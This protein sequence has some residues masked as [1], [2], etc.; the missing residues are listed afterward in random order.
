MAT[1]N[2]GVAVT[3]LQARI[4]QEIDAQLERSDDTPLS[5][6]GIVDTQTGDTRVLDLTWMRKYALMHNAKGERNEQNLR[7]FFKARMY[8][9]TYTNGVRI[10]LEDIED[11]I[12]MLNPEG[13][14][15]TLLRGYRQ[16]LEEEETAMLTNAFN[17]K[18]VGGSMTGPN[19]ETIYQ[20]SMDGEP[21]LSDSHP[22]FE[23]VEFDENAPRPE[24][25]KVID[26]GTFSNLVNT[27]L[28]EDAL[29]SAWESFQTLVDFQGRPANFG[30][31]DTLVV[32]P[33]QA[34]K[35]RQI[36]GRET[37]LV[38]SSANDAAASVENETE[39]LFNIYVN[40]YLTGSV[41]G[42]D[43]DF[44]G[45]TYTDQTIDLDNVWYLVNTDASVSPFVLWN[46]KPFELQMP[47]GTPDLDAENPAEGEITRDMYEHGAV[48]MGG[49]ARFGMS[50]GMPQVIYG[51]L[52]DTTLS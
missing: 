34:R 21:L 13:E 5:E 23:Q 33:K 18:F 22:Y 38:D 50:F 24:R 6:L 51:S 39:D 27:A 25:M 31:P 40:N 37:K 12:G 11:D 45:S 20:G 15:D 52:G 46:R 8:N 41:D 48:R 3:A 10:D 14:A 42:V 1:K 47:V 32:G 4:Q 28:T 49:R 7:R 29:W 19:G 26:G 16:R 44:G 9:D 36:L 35:A 2:R 30:T 43:I 17:K